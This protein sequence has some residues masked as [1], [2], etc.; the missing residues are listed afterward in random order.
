MGTDVVRTRSQESRLGAQLTAE[1]LDY[2][3]S[4]FSD[5]TKKTYRTHLTSYL[6][7]C[8]E[9]DIMPV[10]VNEQTV[11]QYAAYLA[12]RLKP[13]SIKQYINIIRILHLE[14]GLPHPFKDSWYVQTTLK[15]IEKSKG[16]AVNKKTPITPELLHI[17]KRQLNFLCKEDIVFWAAC[18]V[19]FFGVLRKSNLFQD[20]GNFD[21]DKQL[22]R[23]RVVILGTDSVSITFQWSKTIQRKERSVE[24]KLPAMPSHPLCPV[25]AVTEMFHVLGPMGPKAQVFPIKGSDFNKRLRVTAA[26]AGGNFSSHSFRRGGAAWALSCGVP[27]EIVKVMGDW[28]STA[29]LG[30]LDQLPPKVIDSY[31]LHIVRKTPSTST[32]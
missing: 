13:S 8:A 10:P 28:K 9:M 18:L 11:A 22:T 19:L 17:I 30:Y 1:V 31:R 24:I 20:N 12:R 7:F 32:T 29:Y 4:A 25:S 14:S 5:N 3:A 26:V 2:R 6:R 27:G 15:G 16:C 21:P 23:D